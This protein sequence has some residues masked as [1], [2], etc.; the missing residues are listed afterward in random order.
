MFDLTGRVAVVTGGSSGIG[1]QF[2]KALAEQGADVVI[3]ARR[4]DKLETV[5]EEVRKTGRKC[6]PIAADLTKADDIKKAVAEIVEK[7]G[8][9]DILV[10]NAGTSAVAPA[11]SMTDEEWN[12]VVELNLDSV[13]FVAREFGKVMIENKYGR[14]INIAS[15]YGL[16]GSNNPDVPTVVYHA[17]KGGVVNLTRALAAEWAKYNITVNAI[18]PGFFPSE[19]TQGLFDTKEF[20]DYLKMT[21]PMGR[22]GREGELNP[23]LIYLASDE[24]GY[25]TGS[26]VV[27]DGG[28]TA[29]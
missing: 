21:T 4:M 26:M 20:Q 2:A 23:A 18:C 13:F 17:T 19:M 1:V 16:V 9:I 28:T 7:C 22:G 15:M 5:A 29:I 27:V 24:A 12:R 25:T 11:E 8:K 10:N 6:L 14:I 3:I